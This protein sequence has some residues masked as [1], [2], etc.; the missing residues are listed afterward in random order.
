MNMCRGFQ[1]TLLARK[2][3]SDQYKTNQLDLSFVFTWQVSLLISYRYPE[4][5]GKQGL[6]STSFFKLLAIELFSD[7]KIQVYMSF[8]RYNVII[9][10]P[11]FQCCIRHTIFNDCARL[12]KINTYTLF[13]ISI[14]QQNVYS[15]NYHSGSAENKYSSSCHF[16][17][18]I[19]STPLA[20]PLFVILVYLS[21]SNGD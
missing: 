14:R 11:C 7:W 16:Y 1:M 15:R 10:P 12:L 8:E 5:V 17:C 4:Y 20:L 19:V 21:P 13:K 6:S 3:R 9:T 2:R 18:L